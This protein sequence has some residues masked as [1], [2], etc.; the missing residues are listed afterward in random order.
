MKLYT[1]FRSSAAYRVR[2]ALNLKQL[3]AEMIYVHLVKQ[4][5]EH[6]LKEYRE[7]NPNALV[8]TLVDGQATL[9]Q[10]LAILEYLDEVYPN[11]RILPV[12]A[13]SRSQARAIAM[14]IACDIHPVQNLRVLKY[15]TN[16]FHV[17]EEQK[18]AWY[19]HWVSLGL[20]AIESM[21][22]N[23]PQSTFCVGEFP[24]IADICLIP[25]LFNA[26]RVSTDLSAMPNLLRVEENCQK[27]LAF[28][29]AHPSVQA[30][31]E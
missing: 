17:S 20:T 28:Q 5:G 24:T 7:L 22:K 6:L 21:V 23:L 13:V 8:P 15:L 25:Q 3:D 18:N 11:P 1:Y 4:G 9:T 2:I 14:T 12:D 30:D 31:A 26:R 16:E 19:R 10:S 27:I 29:H